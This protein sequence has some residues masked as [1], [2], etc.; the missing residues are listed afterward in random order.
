MIAKCRYVLKAAVLVVGAAAVL[1]MAGCGKSSEIETPA[2]GRGGYSVVD[3]TKTRL[4]FE[5]KPQRIVSLGLSAD[6]VLLD[7]VEP[8]RIAALTYLADDAW[9]FACG[10]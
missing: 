6:E 2:S 4:D 9:N 3:A 7:M 8:D 1:F 10:R 5:H